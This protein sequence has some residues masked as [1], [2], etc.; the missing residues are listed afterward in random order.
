MGFFAIFRGPWVIRFY[1]AFALWAACWLQI[2]KA[3]T[4]NKKNFSFDALCEKQSNSFSPGS[5]VH[6]YR[7]KSKTRSTM[8]K[9]GAV[10]LHLFHAMLAWLLLFYQCERAVLLNIAKDLKLMY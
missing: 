5:A 7:Y 10:C 8:Y 6:G 3:H 9:T 4:N 2:K 1:K